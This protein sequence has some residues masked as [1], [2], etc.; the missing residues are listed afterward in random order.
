MLGAPPPQRKDSVYTH[1]IL[2]SRGGGGGS[3]VGTASP[4][5]AKILPK[6]LIYCSVVFVQKIFKLVL[7]ILLSIKKTKAACLFVFFRHF[8]L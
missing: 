2:Q 5:I 3:S 4:Y 7:A 8:L 6:F 1:P